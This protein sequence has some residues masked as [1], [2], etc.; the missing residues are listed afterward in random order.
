MTRRGEAGT[1]GA[2]TRCLCDRTLARQAILAVVG[3]LSDI[4]QS[5]SRQCLTRKVFDLIG[6]TGPQ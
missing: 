3:A 6:P 1:G 5:C 4:A 2:E